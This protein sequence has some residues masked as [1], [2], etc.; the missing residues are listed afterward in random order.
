MQVAVI[1]VEDTTLTF[2]TVIFDPAFTVAPVAN[3]VPVIVTFLIAVPTNPLLGLMP[4]IDD[5]M[6]QSGVIPPSS[7]GST[8]ATVEEP[9]VNITVSFNNQLSPGDNLNFES[10]NAGECTEKL[11]PVTCNA[12]IPGFWFYNIEGKG[13]VSDNASNWTV[14]QTIVS[15]R[16]AG[17]TKNSSGTLVPF[18]TSVT[19]GPDALTNSTNLQQ[20]A[21]QT[22]IYWIDGPGIGQVVMSNPVDSVTLVQNFQTMFCS[23]VSSGD[24]SSVNWY[25]KIVV[26]PGGILDTAETTAALGSTSTN[27]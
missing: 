26:D 25:E 12:S 8:N 24:C 17:N 9:T 14:T 16:A 10:D 13:V 20:T 11:G 2:E 1:P 18:D 19:P 5:T 3:P 21:G 27:F 6:V 23:T 22:I 4:V 7:D 15:G